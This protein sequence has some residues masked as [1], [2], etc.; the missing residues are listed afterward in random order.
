MS[1][2]NKTAA[3]ADMELGPVGI[4]SAPIRFDAGGIEAAAELERLGYSAIWVPGGI[5]SGVL[6]TLDALLTATATI[7]LGSGILNI[8]KHDP[9]DV[10]AW[11]HRQSPEARQRIILGLGVSHAPLIGDSYQRP[12]ASMRSFLDSLQAAGMP[13]DRV[14]LAALGPRMLELAGQRT[15]GAHPYLVSVRHTAFARRTLG[16]N[17]LLAPE[18]GVVLERSPVKAREIAR[19]FLSHYARLPNYVNNWLRE[20]FTQHELDSLSDR[21]V[22]SI[23]AW[24]DVDAIS[25]RVDEHLAAGADHVCLQVISA[26]G[27]RARLA[28]HMEA[29]RQLA[30]LAQTTR[31][32]PGVNGH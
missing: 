3:A 1:T 24:G 16:S 5:D 22:D 6:G 19:G 12:L 15:G 26:A 21:F 17:A 31:V 20:G 23:I 29:W 14:C 13:L 28:D 11:W 4:W 2:V 18:Q 25:A 9:G 10:A 7:R 8:W 30:R 27:M 32:V